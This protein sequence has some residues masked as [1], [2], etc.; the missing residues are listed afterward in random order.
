LS[1]YKLKSVLKNNRGWWL[2][3]PRPDQFVAARIEMADAIYSEQPET[4]YVLELFMRVRRLLAEAELPIT[5]KTF[6]EV[7]HL[8]AL[9]DVRMEIG[10]ARE[11]S[12]QLVD[13]VALGMAMGDMQRRIDQFRADV[14]VALDD[15]AKTLDLAK[16]AVEIHKRLL[17]GHYVGLSFDDFMLLMHRCTIRALFTGDEN[18]DIE[19]FV[20]TLIYWIAEVEGAQVATHPDIPF[21]VHELRRFSPA[22]CKLVEE[23]PEG[24]PLLRSLDQWFGWPARK[25]LEPLVKRICDELNWHYLPLRDFL[26]HVRFEP[27]VELPIDPN[28]PVPAAPEHKKPEFGFEALRASASLDPTTIFPP[29]LGSVQEQLAEAAEQLAALPGLLEPDT[30]MRDEILAGVPRLTTEYVQFDENDPKVLHPCFRKICYDPAQD[31]LKLA[32]VQRRSVFEID[33]ILPIRNS[34]KDLYKWLVRRE[35]VGD[36]FLTARCEDTPPRLPDDDPSLT[37]IDRYRRYCA[38]CMRSIAR[39]C[40]SGMLETVNEIV[41]PVSWHGVVGRCKGR[42]SAF[43]VQ[44][45]VITRSSGKWINWNNL[46][47]VRVVKAVLPILQRVTPN[48][49]RGV[50]FDDLKKRQRVRNTS[51][52][53]RPPGAPAAVQVNTTGIEQDDEP[54]GGIFATHGELERLPGIHTERPNRMVDGKKDMS[55]WIIVQPDGKELY[56]DFEVGLSLLAPLAFFGDVV[57]FPGRTKRQ[58]IQAVIELFE[59]NLAFAPPVWLAGPIVQILLLAVWTDYEFKHVQYSMALHDQARTLSGVGLPKD[60]MRMIGAP[61][62]AAQMKQALPTALFQHAIFGGVQLLLTI[63][64]NEKAI[65]LEYRSMVE[66]VWGKGYLVHGDLMLAE[67]RFLER[68]YKTIRKKKFKLLCAQ[69]N[70]PRPNAVTEKVESQSRGAPH[71]HVAL[72]FSE[73]L[74]EDS[75]HRVH[76]AVSPEEGTLAADVIMYMFHQHKETCQGQGMTKKCRFKFP[77]GPCRGYWVTKG[78]WV[79]TRDLPDRFLATHA[80]ALNMAAGSHCHSE[81]AVPF[82]ADSAWYLCKY[83]LKPEEELHILFGETPD[84]V[85]KRFGMCSTLALLVISGFPLI[86]F[87]VRPVRLT[88]FNPARLEPVRWD[89]HKRAKVVGLD[90]MIAYMLRPTT[91]GYQPL[92]FLEL[93]RVARIRQKKDGVDDEAVPARERVIRQPLAAGSLQAVRFRARPGTEARI[94]DIEQR[95]LCEAEHMKEERALWKREL[96]EIFSAARQPVPGR[97][98][99]ARVH[100]LLCKGALTRHLRK[101]IPAH[102]FVIEKL[103]KE[104]YAYFVLGDFDVQTIALAQLIMQRPFR[105]FADL[106]PDGNFMNACVHSGVWVRNDLMDGLVRSMLIYGAGSWGYSDKQLAFAIREAESWRYPFDAVGMLEELAHTN[107]TIR[108]RLRG[109][110]RTL[111]AR[112]GQNLE[113]D[114][115]EDADGGARRRRRRPRPEPGAAEN[116]AARR[117]AVAKKLHLD[118]SPEVVGAAE[119]RLR[120]FFAETGDPEQARLLAYISWHRVDLEVNGPIDPV[121]CAQNPEFVQRLSKGVALLGPAGSGKTH[122][123]QRIV[124]LLRLFA[125]RDPERAVHFSSLITASSAKGAQNLELDAST[126]HT[127]F[128]LD[129][130]TN[131][132]GNLPKGSAKREAVEKAGI[133]VIDEMAMAGALTLARV[134]ATAQRVRTEGE[135][136]RTLQFRTPGVGGSLM[137][138]AGDPQ[139]L[140]FVQKEVIDGS[141]AFGQIQL[142]DLWGVVFTNLTGNRRETNPEIRSVL[143]QL[144]GWEGKLG[145]DVLKFF[146]PRF[147]RMVGLPVRENFR[148][149]EAYEEALD[150]AI[151]AQRD[152]MLREAANVLAVDEEARLIASTHDTLNRVEE[153]IVA[154]RRELLLDVGEKLESR[155]FTRQV[156]FDSQVA[157]GTRT[158]FNTRVLCGDYASERQIRSFLYQFKRRHGDAFN[159]RIP[160]E[161]NAW[162][163]RNVLVKRNFDPDKGL[164]NGAEVRVSGFARVVG[165]EPREIVAVEVESDG[166]A[167]DNLL[168]RGME[169]LNRFGLFMVEV[170]STD[171]NAVKVWRAMYA[172]AAA[173]HGTVH[174]FQG[175]SLC[176]RVYIVVEKKMAASTIYTALTRSRDTANNVFIFGTVELSD[177]EVVRDAK[178]D[179]NRAQMDEQ[180]LYKYSCMPLVFPANYWALLADNILLRRFGDRP[181]QFRVWVEAAPFFSEE[182]KEAVADWAENP[183]DEIEGLPIGRL[184]AKVKRDL[185]LEFKPIEYLNDIVRAQ[186]M[187]LRIESRRREPILRQSPMCVFGINIHTP[188]FPDSWQLPSDRDQL[189]REVFVYLELHADNDLACC[190]AELP[191]EAFAGRGDLVQVLLALRAA[192]P[193]SAPAVGRFP[194]ELIAGNDDAQFTACVGDWERD[195]PPLVLPTAHRL[196]AVLAQGRG[197]D[198]DSFTI[199]VRRRDM[200]PG[201]FDRGVLLHVERVPLAE[202][203]FHLKRDEVALC[204][205]YD[206]QWLDGDEDGWPEAQPSRRDRRRAEIDG[207][208]DGGGEETPPGGSVEGSGPGTDVEDFLEPDL[209]PDPDEP[210]PR[211]EPEE[212]FPDVPEPFAVEPFGVKNP[213]AVYCADIAVLQIMASIAPVRALAVWCSTLGPECRPWQ[214]RFARLRGIFAKMLAGEFDLQRGDIRGLAI[215]NPNLSEREKWRQQDVSE[216]FCAVLGLDN[217]L[218]ES[219]LGE[220]FVAR[221]V[222]TEQV[223][224]EPILR[225]LMRTDMTLENALAI[226]VAGGHAEFL[227]AIIALEVNRRIEGEGNERGL[228]L[229]SRA[230]FLF[231]SLQVDVGGIMGGELGSDVFAVFAVVFHIGGEGDGGHY[232]VAQRLSGRWFMC[233]TVTITPF[234]NEGAFATQLDE[235]ACDVAAV[236][237][238]RESVDEAIIW[239]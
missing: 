178:L 25:I 175:S 17:L 29:E 39:V 113:T 177:V 93:Y 111:R 147:Q 88:I 211:P 157:F 1:W 123:I 128:A 67:T 181:V 206:G 199:Y 227:P 85:F 172:L 186:M 121:V 230:N 102:G 86:K 162:V 235:M 229:T 7:L 58:K 232:V 41:A 225:V 193:R 152:N 191:S 54:A 216:V 143:Q 138:L 18:L 150:S 158:G 146:G 233:D 214:K 137:I 2:H 14:D 194:S 3:P 60:Q 26:M 74:P 164:V 5:A 148:S 100:E 106:A 125:F 168:K 208:T 118:N 73:P 47:L 129:I 104:C 10:N 151:A 34:P 56:A 154:R 170:D 91:P 198:A 110:R 215:R 31:R 135:L 184:I 217:A 205:V 77:F 66:D 200:P 90:P 131:K 59:S 4:A 96:A 223:A 101:H 80:T 140:P 220:L 239:R 24:V 160:L 153:L 78:A 46:R 221:L 108:Q 219:E 15:E 43:Q 207:E 84:S 98:D 107:E 237:M 210:P 180:C 174:H 169:N 204:C 156:Y 12:W 71:L 68:F 212:P 213:G 114:D 231:D 155:F 226:V 120:S 79:G 95:Q 21:L 187:R 97:R 173:C 81:L 99:A 196:T 144:S 188:S 19:F 62:T 167:A 51:P 48:R 105:C 16:R 165:P 50:T 30:R 127:A 201:V 20:T 202:V 166:I 132:V 195:L 124:D 70:I 37:P 35:I 171:V 116:E 87:S 11:F 9:E 23:A 176:G 72:S 149:D 136:L 33:G 161:L 65:P 64:T 115:A 117:A 36:W 52:W 141:C 236:F 8:L 44:G 145:G 218:T 57:A 126:A 45:R 92:K 163:G 209:E 179:R 6:P 82:Q 32:T 76:L 133:V 55:Y 224:G 103:P 182:D 112:V 53:R 222:D 22:F 139:Q 109:L 130:M 190:I 134:E 119:R 185:Q 234:A 122:L 28:G 83:V 42:A 38:I 94:G 197:E 89:L 27:R 228:T 183:S 159:P 13:D 192:F 49:Y 189:L 203:A 238:V 69:L 61:G 40:P 142:C 75:Y 63:T